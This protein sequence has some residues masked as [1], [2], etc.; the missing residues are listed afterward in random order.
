MMDL[1]IPSQPSS[2]PGPGCSTIGLTVFRETKRNEMKR[3]ETKRKE[4]KR[5]ENYYYLIIILLDKVN[6]AL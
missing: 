5:N 2:P 1:T 4:T 3:N 6:T